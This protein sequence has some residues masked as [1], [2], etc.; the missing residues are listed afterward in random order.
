MFISCDMEKQSK[1]S[2][3]QKLADD[4]N[5]DQ[6]FEEYLA[7]REDNLKYTSLSNVT[8]HHEL[9][10][11][12]IQRSVRMFL[13]KRSYLKIRNAVLVIQAWYRIRYSLKKSVQSLKVG[14]KSKPTNYVCRVTSLADFK[15]LIL[16]VLSR[17]HNSQSFNQVIKKFILL[18]LALQNFNIRSSICTL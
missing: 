14:Y 8:A 4:S 3:L 13:S 5:L 1:S 2:I 11:L 6:N 7:V 18:T 10:I 17:L 9:C 15:K 16:H 12:I